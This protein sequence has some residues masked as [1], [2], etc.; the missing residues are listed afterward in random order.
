MLDTQRFLVHTYVNCENFTSVV[1]LFLLP[2]VNLSFQK[3]LILTAA[4]EW[5][6]GTSPQE[7]KRSLW[8]MIRLFYWSKNGNFHVY[9]FFFSF[10]IQSERTNQHTFPL[11][12]KSIH[13]A[14][15]A[16]FLIF[17]SQEYQK[18]DS[19]HVNE[20]N[21]ASVSCKPFTKAVDYYYT[22]V[23]ISNQ[24]LGWLVVN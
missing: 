18:V 22:A 6:M 2:Y 10:P 20:T 23:V 24:S 17:F 1:S 15:G 7:I 3:I 8:S 16:N 5:Y 12:P 21:N 19:R 14:T 4:G 13:I 9:S 11:T